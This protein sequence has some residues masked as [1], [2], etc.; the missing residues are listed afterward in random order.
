[1]GLPTV[2]PIRVSNAIPSGLSQF[3]RLTVRLSPNPDQLA[4][5]SSPGWVLKT[6]VTELI[7]GSVNGTVIGSPAAEIRVPEATISRSATLLVAITGLPR[8]RDSNNLTA[9]R[10]PPGT[11]QPPFFFAGL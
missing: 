7:P 3:V 1:M 11:P 5:C 2:S 6:N 9:T 4:E 10:P 8:R